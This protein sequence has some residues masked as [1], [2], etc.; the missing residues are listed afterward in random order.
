MKFDKIFG[1]QTWFVV[2]MVGG[3]I[4][5]GWF[6]SQDINEKTAGS[7][8]FSEPVSAENVVD[9]NP[10][11]EFGVVS[12]VI[13]S[14]TIVMDNK[15][16]VRY[17]GAVTPTTLDKVECFGKEALQANESL[18]GKTVRL[19]EDPVI[20]RA[21]DKAWIRYVWVAEDEKSQEAYNKALSGA[22]VAGLN[23]PVEESEAEN[24][25]ENAPT[26][27]ERLTEDENTEGLEVSSTPINEAVL[28]STDASEEEQSEETKE[29]KIKEYLVSERIIEMGLGF[30]LLSKEMT[31]Y[32]KLS[33]ATRFSS[34]TKRGLWGGCEISEGEN[35]LLKTQTVDEC[36]I[37]GVKLSN[38]EQIFRVP[39]CKAYKDTVV[40]GYKDDEWL[41]SEEDAL[42]KGYVK[43]I[44]C[45]DDKAN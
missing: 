45:I 43:A 44:D 17:L 31:Y 35:G 5:V 3:I 7:A 16:V 33:A 14:L 24:A 30:P 21:I 15:Y 6:L 34:A 38:K 8:D 13:D 28:E 25:P 29:D 10:P 39:G 37:K 40:L 23:I 18:L 22:P 11:P 19:E 4:W 2:L 36:V 27:E 9:D 20:T 42:E 12:D 32:E 26:E 41:C 1:L